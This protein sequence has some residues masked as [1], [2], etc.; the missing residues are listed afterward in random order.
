MGNSSV[1]RE[2]RCWICSALGFYMRPRPS[3]LTREDIR[4]NPETLE[5]GTSSPNRA[6]STRGGRRRHAPIQIEEVT[7]EPSRRHPWFC[8]AA[9]AGCCLLFTW[10]IAENGWKFQPFSCPATCAYGPCFEDGKVCEANPLLGPTNAV[11]NQLG[12]KNDDAIFADHEWWRVFTCNWL[13]AG[14]F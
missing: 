12:A 6:V 1:K 10:E 4:F 2:S 7:D 9:F 3:D 13:H 14:L 11:M 8:A 5:F